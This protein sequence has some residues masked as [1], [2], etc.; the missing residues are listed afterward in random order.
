M[1]LCVLDSSG[2]GLHFRWGQAPEAAAAALWVWMLGVALL[3]WMV[4]PLDGGLWGGM[5]RSP[6]G[7]RAHVA[8]ACA[9]AGVSCVQHGLP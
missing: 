6:R 7:A 8:G 5:V 3:L 2:P 9:S 1:T 4:G